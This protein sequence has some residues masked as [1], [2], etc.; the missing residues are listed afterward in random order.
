[1]IDGQRDIFGTEHR[2]YGAGEEH[3]Q[4]E[5]F[6]PEPEQLAGQMALGGAGPEQ[7]AE[8]RDERQESN[9]EE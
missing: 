6:T 5:L 1:M 8:R 2:Y 9:R 3:E 7:E 4:D